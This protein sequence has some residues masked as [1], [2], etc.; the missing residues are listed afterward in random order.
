M[1]AFS[2]ELDWTKEMPSVSGEYY[3][4]FPHEKEAQIESLGVDGM[5]LFYADF[6]G[7]DVY[8]NKDQ[9]AW[10]LGPL[11]KPMLPPGFI[12]RE[13]NKTGK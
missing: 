3:I 10:F 8:L 13:A 5:G 4:L 9:E 6:R 1:S 7:N 2:A 12:P 11:P